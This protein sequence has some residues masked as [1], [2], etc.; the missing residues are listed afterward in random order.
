MINITVLWLSCNYNSR[1]YIASIVS[2]SE[3]NSRRFMRQAKQFVINSAAHFA[4][5]IAVVAT[6]TSLF[7]SEVVGYIPCLLCWYQRIAM[8][9][10]V[11]VLA[12]GILTKDKKLPAYALPFS[13][14]GAGIA[15]I[16]ILVE[17]GIISE[18]SLPCRV[19]V[20]CSTKYV[21]YLGF[22]TIPLMSFVAFVVI[23]LLVY[24]YWRTNKNEG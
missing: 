16:H 24:L 5:V 2:A 4:W 19:G 11:I 7:Y 23:T 9:P 15:F 18:A 3:C 1:N 14:I 12:V 22:I 21:N 17:R 10:L 6:L 13:I 20:S 8:Y